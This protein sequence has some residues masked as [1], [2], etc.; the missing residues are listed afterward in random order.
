MSSNWQSS[1]SSWQ[2]N[3][4]SAWGLDYEDREPESAHSVIIS[5]PAIDQDDVNTDE[6]MIDPADEPEGNL[7]GIVRQFSPIVVPLLIGGLIFLLTFFLALKN[8]TFLHSA[9]LLPFGLTLLAV[10]II[11]G[12][13][14]YYAGNSDLYWLIG[15][16]TGFAIFLLLGCFALFGPIISLLLLIVLISL[17][18]MTVRFCFHPV[19][20]GQVQILYAFGKYHRTLFP[21]LNYTAPWEH[22]QSTFNTRETYWAC[23]MQKIQISRDEDIQLAAAIFYQLMPEDAH[24]ALL[25]VNDWEESL[26][27]IF[28]TTLQS[29]ISELT[30]EDF[31]AWPHGFASRQLSAME[32]D[33]NNPQE[34]YLNRWERVN[35]RLTQRVQDQ[36][37]TWGIQINSIKIQDITLIPR[38]I[39][40]RETGPVMTLSSN[41]RQSGP[42]RDD[43][44]TT[45]KR[46]IQTPIE[47]SGP[48]VVTSQNG[49]I[50]AKVPN[51]NPDFTTV[52]MP[53][54]QVQP[55]ASA[56]PAGRPTRPANKDA[57][58]LKEEALSE[59]YASVRDGR[60]T[61][62][63]TIR[64]IARRFETLANNPEA[65]KDVSFDALRGAQAL[66][67]RADVLEE[68]FKEIESRNS[69]QPDSQ[70]R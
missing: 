20:E 27:E 7:A 23:P 55:Q 57:R 60:I 34:D 56:N 24:L 16:S 40:P 62:P 42:F 50:T 33:H 46:I 70:G 30:P 22:I 36:V 61:D 26:H 10:A 54:P 3:H 48:Q 69:G 9:G 41:R 66:F 19:P 39:K 51:V 4:D 32:L 68:H 63:T 1:D 11:Q 25:Y 45:G 37:A 59:A 14:L 43:P 52:S 31:I 17:A 44:T 49:K 53:K 15:F 47:D 2:G 21:G 29:V 35:T 13:F 8:F 64:S 67:Q 6:N 28:R 12:T 58:S 18:I 5:N 38:I 65:S